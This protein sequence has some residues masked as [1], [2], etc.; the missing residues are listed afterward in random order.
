MVWLFSA[1]FEWDR[2]EIIV[3]SKT[4]LGQWVWGG[5]VSVRGYELAEFLCSS[6][7]PRLFHWPSLILSFPP[8]LPWA[9][10]PKSIVSLS[11]RSSI[12]FNGSTM[13][14]SL[15][16]FWAQHWTLSPDK[17]PSS[18]SDPSRQLIHTHTHSHRHRQIKTTL[19]E[20][21]DS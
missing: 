1:Q 9:A 7:S 18:R 12:D 17:I 13:Y 15:R 19:A 6:N 4:D 16:C 5:R 14:L 11:C 21:T 10:F 8:L 20:Y 3:F 2:S